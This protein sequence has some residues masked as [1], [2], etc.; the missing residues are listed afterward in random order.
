MKTICVLVAVLLIAEFG[1]CFPSQMDGPEDSLQLTNMMTA[2]PQDSLQEAQ[3]KP[4]VRRR[5]WSWLERL[6][7]RI[8]RG[9]QDHFT[10]C[11]TV[12]KPSSSNY[13]SSSCGY[14]HVAT[15]VCG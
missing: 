10:G 2:L 6:G 4:L 1:R 5:R 15:R 3:M 13:R 12:C 14:G 8:Y 9:T 7:A 11:R